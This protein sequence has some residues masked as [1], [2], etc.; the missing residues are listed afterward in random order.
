[1]CRLIPPA[2]RVLYWR[3]FWPGKAWMRFLTAWFLTMPVGAQEP[4]KAGNSEQPARSFQV[5][6]RWAIDRGDHTVIFQRV[7]PPP[8]APPAAP[9]LPPKVP[10]LSPQE[11]EVMRLR[12][13]K[14]HRVLFLSA[15]VFDHRLTELRWTEEDRKYRAFSNID[16]QYFG[17][18]GEIE[19]ADT[20]YT[21]MIAL[22]SG[23]AEELAERTRESPQV[24]LLPKERAAWVLA[25]GKS[26]ESTPVMAAWDS[27]HT[28]YDAHR[29]ELT[30]AY[31]QRAAA[32]AERQRQ[33]R[34]HPPVPKNKVIS[35]W[36]KP[37][38]AAQPEKQEAGK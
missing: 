26:S 5:L 21:L 7:A 4:V 1:M 25:E 32:I 31:E 12:E 24:A 13:A 20:I 27:L 6:K 16:F 22:D 38:P 28:Y 19:T 34:E 17:G 3:S 9:V 10:E 15:T 29:E 18:M 14:Q 11:L 33:L 35:Y 2:V 30:K 37:N 23:T 36:K 8:A